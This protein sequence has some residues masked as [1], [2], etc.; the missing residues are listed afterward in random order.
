MICEIAIQSQ[1]LNEA[2]IRITDPMP[3]RGIGD[4][5]LE[6]QDVSSP[7]SRNAKSRKHLMHKVVVT[8]HGHEKGRSQSK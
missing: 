8:S 5:D 6:S 4:H 1:P 3:F 7:E 2:M